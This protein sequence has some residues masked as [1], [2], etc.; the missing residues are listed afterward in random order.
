MIKTIILFATLS[1]QN[2]VQ[3]DSILTEEQAVSIALQSN[4][5][6]RLE[7]FNLDI[8]KN[9]NTI[10]NAGFLPTVEAT[11]STSKTIQNTELK[12]LTRSDTTIN[13]AQTTSSNAGVAL[14][15]TLF[16]GLKMFATKE[17]LEQISRSNE[18]LFKAQVQNTISD[19]LKAF[20]NAALE[21]ERLRLLKSNLEL[22]E[23]R[24]QIS[25]DK[26]EVGKASKMEYLQA[27][28]DYNADQ[29]AF[30]K[31]KEVIAVKLY[32]LQQIMGLDQA[33]DNLSLDF[34]YD[35]GLV[36]SRAQ[37]E[38]KALT[39]NPDLQS[40][41]MDREVSILATKE[42][43]R[44]RLPSLDFNLGYNYAKSESE[45]GFLQRSKSNGVNYGLS[46]E[47]TIFDGL[48]QSRQIQNAKIQAEYSLTNYEKSKMILLTSVR[49]AFLTYQNAVEL[50]Q[51]ETKN[52]EVA[53]ENVNIALERYR[54]GKSNPLEIREAQ[55]NAVDAQI[56]H[57]EA[58]NTAKI[59]EVEL[60]RL[61]GEIV[62]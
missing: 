10:G 62:N 5:D 13:G 56:R 6:I 48:N 51:L 25:K 50:A 18:Y 36:I 12:Y 3:I 17:K 49:S 30:V 41:F 1:A 20:F 27:Q 40:M 45:S 4:Y 61:T 34:S 52:L 42:L 16:D 15:W 11:A 44:T 57:L 53:E 29:S 38:E 33:K 28:V 60:L 37:A 39:Q 31:Q 24:V 47:F 22:S 14:T 35:L 46:A 43:E 9:N 59:A 58:L 19:V 55:N 2:P 32:E 26:Y 7:Q 23:E 8:A 54:V 21:Q